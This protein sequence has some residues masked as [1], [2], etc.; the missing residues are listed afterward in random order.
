MMEPAQGKSMDQCRNSNQGEPSERQQ[1]RPPPQRQNISEFSHLTMVRAQPVFPEVDVK[2][3]P[4]EI[5]TVKEEV[6]EDDEPGSSQE[7]QNIDKGN[8]ATPEKTGQVGGRRIPPPPP[9]LGPIRLKPKR[10][11]YSPY[12]IDPKLKWSNEALPF[13][14]RPDNYAAR[15]RSTASATVTSAASVAPVPP[16]TTGPA[17]SGRPQCNTVDLSVFASFL[18]KPL[19]AVKMPPR[20]SERSASDN[21]N[22]N[23]TV[24]PN[25]LANATTLE[26]TSET[27][28]VTGERRQPRRPKSPSLLTE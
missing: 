25:P 4:G 26:T 15:R 23:P 11:K 12:E 2:L 19:F 3:E 16:N 5:I 22:P 21:Q 9:K 6:V 10:Y 13:V 18:G 24:L 27:T 20:P 28:V 1:Q 8:N 14:S 17:S 7:A